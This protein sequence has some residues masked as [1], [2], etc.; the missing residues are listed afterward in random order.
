MNKNG[1]FCLSMMHLVNFWRNHGRLHAWVSPC[2]KIGEKH[3]CLQVTAIWRHSFNSLRPSDALT[4]HGSGITLANGMPSQIA[5]FMGPTWGPHGSC[6]SQMGP[7]WAPWTLLSGL[8]PEAPNHY[9]RQRWT[10]INEVMLRSH[11]IIF[12]TSAKDTNP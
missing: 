8:I 1:V 6:R 7:M 12:A 5:K 9:L 2:R 4:W 3:I 11:E 10:A